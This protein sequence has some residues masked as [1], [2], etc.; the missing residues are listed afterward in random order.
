VIIRQ[1]LSAGR[2][3]PKAIA[4]APGLEQGNEFFY[5]AFVSLNT[6]RLTDYGGIPWTAVEQYAQRYCID[7]EQADL[8][9]GVIKEVDQWFLDY[10]DKK[11]KAKHKKANSSIKTK[12]K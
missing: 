10:Q 6:C 7:E 5:N 11:Q 3:L 1:A 8:L 12:G 9:H 2:P 4:E